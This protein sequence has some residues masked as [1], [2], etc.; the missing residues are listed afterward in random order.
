V[1]NVVREADKVGG[2]WKE[3]RD[4]LQQKGF[5]V[6]IQY[7]GEFKPGQKKEIRDVWISK[8]DNHQQKS[9][10]FFKK[11]LGFSLSAI[12]SGFGD[13]VKLMTANEAVKNID[14]YDSHSKSEKNES[15]IE[16][17]GELLKKLLK[18][19]YIVQGDDELW[20]KKRKSR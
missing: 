10:L 18:P 6:R 16:I 3:F 15:V 1:K 2:N 14:N 19:N 5:S 8:V 4:Y 11:N 13:L 17:S 20:K 9:G 7:D 12:D